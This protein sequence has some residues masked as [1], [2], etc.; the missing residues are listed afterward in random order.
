VGA[1]LVPDHQAPQVCQ[2]LRGSERQASG[3]RRVARRE[4]PRLT[5]S[6]HRQPLPRREQDRIYLQVEGQLCPTREP[7]LSAEDQGYREAKAVV[8]FSQHDVA[9]VSKERHEILHKVLQAKI[10]DREE[11]RGLC[12]QVYQQAHGR[13]GRRSDRAGRGGALE[14]AEGGGLTAPR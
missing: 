8:A 13:A 7:R 4:A 6:P 9:E 14:L 12:E 10:T 1:V 5:T 3:L 11:F 2:P